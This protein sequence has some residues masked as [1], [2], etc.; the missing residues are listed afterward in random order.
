MRRSAQ[1]WTCL[2]GPELSA[3]R[4]AAARHALVLDD[5]AIKVVLG[6]D[7]AAKEHP[8]IHAGV[9][10]LEAGV[11]HLNGIVVIVSGWVRVGCARLC[12]VHKSSLWAGL[13]GV[14]APAGPFLYPTPSLYTHMYHK[15]TVNKRFMVQF[16]KYTTTTKELTTMLTEVLYIGDRLRDLRKR[17]LLTQKEL[18]DKSG[19][20]VTTIIRIERNQ[21]EPQGSTI[22]K[23]A[24]ALSVAPEELVKSED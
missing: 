10:T 13:R 5:L 7:N 15:S 16:C 6:L 19:V 8:A 12:G 24:R 11:M 9:G 2:I 18:A 23:L 14:A 3:I 1:T 4:A 20:G 17:A 22:R 21:V